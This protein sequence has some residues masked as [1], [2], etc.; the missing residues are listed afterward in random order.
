MI[1]KKLGFMFSEYTESV[2][3]AHKSLTLVLEAD[4]TTSKDTVQ[5]VRLQAFLNHLALLRAPG[6]TPGTKT[7]A[8]SL[9]LHPTPSPKASS[10][11]TT[12]FL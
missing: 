5:S 12:D 2:M 9:T 7:G 3:M 10:L 6:D 4:L 8:K 11:L 1:P